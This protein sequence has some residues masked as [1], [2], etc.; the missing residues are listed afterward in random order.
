MGLCGSSG[1]GGSSASGFDADQQRD[2]DAAQPVCRILNIHPKDGRK[3]LNCYEEV[4][5][6]GRGNAHRYATTTTLLPAHD[7]HNKH[8]CAVA[9]TSVPTNPGHTPSS[10]TLCI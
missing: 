5:K 8:C 9:R 6:S 10:L 4:L 2:L 1:G 3:F 7:K